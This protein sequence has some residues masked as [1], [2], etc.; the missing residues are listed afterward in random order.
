MCGAALH[1]P[2]HL[3]KFS[4]LRDACADS[5]LKHERVRANFADSANFAPT[6]IPK[7]RIAL[8]LYALTNTASLSLHSSRIAWICCAPRS[9]SPLRSA[10]FTVLHRSRIRESRDMRILKVIW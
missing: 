10:S 2:A 8:E 7:K 9:R 1:F 3:A 4:Q 6:L 5:Q